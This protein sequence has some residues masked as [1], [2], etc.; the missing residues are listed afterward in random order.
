MGA[1]IGEHNR[2]IQIGEDSTAAGKQAAAIIDGALR[3]DPLAGRHIETSDVIAP[4]TK[5]RGYGTRTR[6]A[7]FATGAAPAKRTPKPATF[8]TE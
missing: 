4:D 5:R 6:V 7:R 1:A 8:S 2:L 3:A